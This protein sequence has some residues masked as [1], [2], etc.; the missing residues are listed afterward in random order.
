M[1]ITIFRRFWRILCSCRPNTK[2][3]KKTLVFFFKLAKIEHQISIID[4]HQFKIVLFDI[5]LYTEKNA[6]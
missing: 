6:P 2:V 4:Q 5:T 1:C 3:H